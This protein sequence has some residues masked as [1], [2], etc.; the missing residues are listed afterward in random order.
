[1][2]EGGGMVM[3]SGYGGYQNNNP[4]VNARNFR[5]SIKGIEINILTFY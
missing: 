5:W 4:S 3:G 2:G 1:M